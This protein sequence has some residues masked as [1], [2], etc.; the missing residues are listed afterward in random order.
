MRA[1]VAVV[2]SLF[3]VVVAVAAVFTWAMRTKSPT[4]Q[5]AIRKMNRRFVNPRQHDA[6]HP[7]AYASL[8]RHVGRVTGTAYE[9]PVVAVPTDDGFVIVL[10][11]G[12][13]ADWCQNVLAAGSATIMH[14]GGAHEV[15][16]PELL[17][18]TTADALVSARDRRTHRLFGVRQCLRLHRVEPGQDTSRSAERSGST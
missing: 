5:G 2:G 10:P 1:V 17:P 7:G 3:L 4:V 11:Y 16:G 9:T 15:I 12:P 8:V 13:G 14:D 18:I 6:G